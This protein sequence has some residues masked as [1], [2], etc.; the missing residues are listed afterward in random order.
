MLGDQAATSIE[1]NAREH[2][3]SRSDRHHPRRLQ[4]LVTYKGRSG[5]CSRLTL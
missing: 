3:T 2:D 1:L 5:F 4:T